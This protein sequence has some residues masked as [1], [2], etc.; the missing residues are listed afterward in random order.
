MQEILPHDLP[1]AIDITL[2]KHNYYDRL[3]ASYLKKN[4]RYSAVPENNDCFIVSIEDFRR[5]IFSKFK[6][7]IN[8][9]KSLTEVELGK[10]TNS[11]FFINRILDNFQNLKFIK[12]NISDKR[13]FS[14]LIEVE[15][16]R[17]VINFDYKI[18]ASVIDLTQF[19]HKKADY[20]YINDIFKKIGLIND[21][22]FGTRVSYVNTTSQE[23]IN[24]LV[25]FENKLHENT[26]NFTDIQINE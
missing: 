20:Y 13:K 14:R 17:T 22:I 5:I 25:D 24:L 23:L 19:F 18:L 2:Y 26:A 21:D 11:I 4:S 7:E 3:I 9:L 1:Y 15:K 8:S 10:N 12:V 6:R 16:N